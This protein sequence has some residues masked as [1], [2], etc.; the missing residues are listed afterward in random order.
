MGARRMKMD[1]VVGPLLQHG[2]Q[3]HSG[4]DIDRITYP[5]WAAYDSERLRCLRK[6][7]F[8]IAEDLRIMTGLEKPARQSQHLAL[9]AAKITL[10][11]DSSDS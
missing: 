9:A 11:I 5:Q 8:G 3:A 4:R 2:T 7:P 6:H 1:D 10:R